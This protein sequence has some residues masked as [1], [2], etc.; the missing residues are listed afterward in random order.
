MKV[1]LKCPFCGSRRILSW[2]EVR[3]CCKFGHG[4]YTIV[5]LGQKR[6]ERVRVEFECRDCGGKFYVVYKL[7]EIELL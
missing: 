3:F 7:S 2:D 5:D 4:E 1:K 6:I